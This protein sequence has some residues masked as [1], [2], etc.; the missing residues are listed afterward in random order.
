MARGPGVVTGRSGV[1]G[2][3]FYAHD[4]YWPL[5]TALWVKQFRAATPTYAFQY[6]QTMDLAR[7]NAGSAVPT[8][9]RNHVHAQP[10]V[11]PPGGGVAAYTA[12]TEPLLRRIRANSEHAG[13]LEAI[14]DA[15]LPRI[16]SGKLRLPE[17]QG[18]LEEAIA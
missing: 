17:E 3:V 8:L 6:L 11:I 15:V 1:I 13:A 16:I 7:L 5:N 18:Q 2:R 14:R 12:V 4:D 10:A 9:N